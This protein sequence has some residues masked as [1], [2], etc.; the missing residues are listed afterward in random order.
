MQEIAASV[1]ER[2]LVQRFGYL[3]DEL[4]VQVQL[5]QV[6][7]H[8]DDDGRAQRVVQPH[9]L[10][11][12]EAGDLDHKGGHQHAQIKAAHHQPAEAELKA[13]QAISCN[14]PQQHVEENTHHQNHGGV[15][16][17]HGSSFAPSTSA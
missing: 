4:H 15:F 9:A 14:G 1:D 7:R 13:L 3:A 17:C 16:H 10:D 12:L 6:G 8:I 2:A 5:H 11:D